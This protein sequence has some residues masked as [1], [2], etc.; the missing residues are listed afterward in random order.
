MFLPNQIV[1]SILIIIAVTGSTFLSINLVVYSS[2][3]TLQACSWQVC[4]SWTSDWRWR[5]RRKRRRKLRARSYF[6]LWLNHSQ[7]W[8]LRVPSKRL[9]HLYSTPL[10]IANSHITAATTA[11]SPSTRFTEDVNK[12]TQYPDI[13][14]EK[15]CA[16][17][18]AHPLFSRPLRSKGFVW[19]ATRPKQSCV[20]SS[21]SHTDI[22]A[23]LTVVHYAVEGPM[24]TL[25]WW[26]RE[27]V[28][29]HYGEWL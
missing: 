28:E 16:N 1:K 23:R 22:L 15:S 18:K 2:W 8:A 12:L 4:H 25:T 7:G 27:G 5:C 29:E 13:P 20:I 9:S 3:T 24:T 19:L 6:H 10:A 17:K 26:C 14:L 21:G 11:T